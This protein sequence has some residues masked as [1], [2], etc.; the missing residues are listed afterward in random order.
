MFGVAAAPSKVQLD[1]NSCTSKVPMST[2]Y[3]GKH[4]ASENP[5]EM[6]RVSRIEGG[7]HSSSHVEFGRAQAQASPRVGLSG[8][9]GRHKRV[10]ARGQAIANNSLACTRFSTT[11]A[12][13]AER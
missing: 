8:R 13:V 4:R 5:M 10:I 12:A 2:R 6:K 7:E 1:A 9:T 3:V 11:L